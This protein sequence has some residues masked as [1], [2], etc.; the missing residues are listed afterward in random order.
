METRGWGWVRGLVAQW[1][2][3]IQHSRQTKK[4]TS[5]FVLKS[6]SRR[7]MVGKLARFGHERKFLRGV[8]QNGSVWAGIIERHSKQSA[9]RSDVTT[10][11]QKEGGVPVFHST[12]KS[13]EKSPAAHQCRRNTLTETLNTWEGK[14]K[15]KIKTLR[16]A[17]PS[18]QFKTTPIHT[19]LVRSML[20][21]KRVHQTR[22]VNIAQRNEGKTEPQSDI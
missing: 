1:E 14:R 13:V 8:K 20:G 10:D 9:G 3:T 17:F 2:K 6:T 4:I 22:N 7:E 12:P 18:Y 19:S 16:K 5:W 11:K 15:E 21:R